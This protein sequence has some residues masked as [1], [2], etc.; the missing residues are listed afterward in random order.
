MGMNFVITLTGEVSVEA[1]AS[2]MGIDIDN[3][4][5]LLDISTSVQLDDVQV[6][7]SVTVEASARVED[8]E[9]AAED[10]DG[11]DADIALG[12]YVSPYG[13]ASVSNADFEITEEP[14]GFDTVTQALGYDRDQ[15]IAVYAALARDGYEVS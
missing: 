15:A 1:A 10:L 11:Y 9:V 3:P 7:G 12:E 2:D 6:S 14:T 13:G 8:V 5:D 4:N